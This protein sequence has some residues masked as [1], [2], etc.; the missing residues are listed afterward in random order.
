MWLAGRSVSS[1]ADIHEL[2]IMSSSSPDYI[3]IFSKARSRKEKDDDKD[4]DE[5]DQR[6]KEGDEVLSPDQEKACVTPYLS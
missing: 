2:L 4:K 5:D 3:F 1:R 6:Q